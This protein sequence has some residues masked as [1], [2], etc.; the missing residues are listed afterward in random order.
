MYQPVQQRTEGNRATE[1]KGE[2]QED[3]KIE[4][5]PYSKSSFTDNYVN[6][7]GNGDTISCVKQ[8]QV[9]GRATNMFYVVI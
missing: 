6:S 4:T 8:Q 5:L 2:C 9:S 1:V 3:E 7:C